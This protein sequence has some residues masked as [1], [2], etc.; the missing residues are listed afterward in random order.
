MFCQNRSNIENY[1]ID[2]LTLVT[3]IGNRKFYTDWYK[4]TQ[5]SL[6]F[7]KDTL[8]SLTMLQVVKLEMFVLV[9]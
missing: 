3:T 8:G 9:S 6:K 2:L 4:V 1:E 5:W 7:Q